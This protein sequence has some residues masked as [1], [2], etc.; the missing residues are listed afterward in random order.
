MQLCLASIFSIPQNPF[1]TFSTFFVSSQH[2][3]NI[4]TLL[5]IEWVSKQT[6]VKYKFPKVKGPHSIPTLLL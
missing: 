5:L 1:E 2:F 6:L 3:Q 4:S